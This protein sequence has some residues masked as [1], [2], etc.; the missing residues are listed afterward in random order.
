MTKVQVLLPLKDSPAVKKYLDETRNIWENPEFRKKMQL[1]AER[2]F[3]TNKA[4][5]R[6][7]IIA[8]R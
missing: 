4:G 3:E 6:D 7:D 2:R 1:E 8:G 5:N